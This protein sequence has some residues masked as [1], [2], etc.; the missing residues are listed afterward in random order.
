ML[1]KRILKTLLGILLI[2]LL[3]NL[4]SPILQSLNFGLDILWS[5]IKH[6]WIIILITGILKYLFILFYWV[7][8]IISSLILGVLIGAVPV[9]IINVILTKI[10][11]EEEVP[12]FPYPTQPTFIEY[13]SLLSTIII[14]LVPSVYIFID[15]FWKY[16][17]GINYSFF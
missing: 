11:S 10:S 7:W 17:S 2:I 13:F 15:W 14:C 3:L 8:F 9:K 4:I 6:T 5:N 16:L 12:Y 1:F